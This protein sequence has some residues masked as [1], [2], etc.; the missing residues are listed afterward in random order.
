MANISTIDMVHLD[1]LFA[2]ES[3]YVLD[4]TDATMRNFYAHDLNIDIDHPQYRVDGHSKARR[5]RCLL[6]QISDADAIRVL[7]A[8][9]DYRNAMFLARGIRE[10]VMNAEGL[11]LSVITRLA[12]LT[13]LA[14][15]IAIAPAGRAFDWT[16]LAALQNHLVSLQTMQPHARG[17][18]FEKF[19][20]DVFHHF[21][22]SPRG[23]FRLVGEQIDGSFQHEGHTY[24]V[25]AKWQNAPTG[26]ADLHVFEGKLRE[27]AAWSRGLFVSYSGFSVDGLIAFGR[28]KRSLCM[29]GLDLYELLNRK[30]PLGDV[31]ARKARQAAETARVFVGVRELFL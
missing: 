26:A 14:T 7:R 30:L 1:K 31:I 28:D 9:W 13:P 17:Y 4:F 29:D 8:L 16:K 24:L 6:R 11:F 22:L 25:E 15:P 2:M 27:K 3:G 12:G 18:A 5:T 23:S 21:G 19:L 10:P 20:N